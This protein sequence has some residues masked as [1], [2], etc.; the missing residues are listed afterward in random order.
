M[1]TNEEF[2]YIKQQNLRHKEGLVI[3]KHVAESYYNTTHSS[4]TKDIYVRLMLTIL[5][6]T[7]LN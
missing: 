1:S 4:T 3:I 2:I 6:K 7:D 5:V